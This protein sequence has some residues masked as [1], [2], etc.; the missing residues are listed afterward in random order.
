MMIIDAFLMLLVT[1]TMIVMVNK[2]KQ[3]CMWIEYNSWIT[4][5]LILIETLPVLL[6]ALLKLLG[7]RRDIDH[8]LIGFSFVLCS[9]GFATMVKTIYLFTALT[10]IGLTVLLTGLMLFLALYLRDSNLLFTTTLFVI[11]C[12]SIVAGLILYIIEA[13]LDKGKVLRIATGVCF[14]FA[15]I[16]AVFLTFV[17]LCSQYYAFS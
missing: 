4:I 13:T 16:L 2:V 10:A 14:L 11:L 15:V 3:L 12:V 5:V 8:F 17:W 7:Y 6:L 9:M 1:L